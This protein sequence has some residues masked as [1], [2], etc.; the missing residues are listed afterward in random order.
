MPLG[1]AYLLDQGL[2][3][4]FWP[5]LGLRRRLPET[6]KEAWLLAGAVQVRGVTWGRSGI[7]DCPQDDSQ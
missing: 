5:K 4:P 2:N 3:L 1:D 7:W 6:F